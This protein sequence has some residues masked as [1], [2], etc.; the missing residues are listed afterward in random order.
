MVFLNR[1]Y[2]ATP[3]MISEDITENEK[4]NKVV[5]YINDNLEEDLTLERLA[6]VCFISKSYLS[7]Q[8]KE[9]TGLT[10][11]QFIIKKRLT[12]A[13]NMIREGIPVME[14]CMRCGFNDYSN[15]HK[16]FRKEFGS[17]PKEFR[18]NK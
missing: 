13:R 3:D 8:F 12:V 11:F 4:I 2:F 6:E 16:A 14:A 9:Y 10:V 7:H 5:S 15:F 1:A 18:P 17:S